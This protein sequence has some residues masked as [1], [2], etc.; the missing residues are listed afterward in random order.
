MKITYI[1]SLYSLKH[2]TAV[3]FWTSDA[4]GERERLHRFQITKSKL[5]HMEAYSNLQN[6]RL[7]SGT[8]PDNKSKCSRKT[9]LW[10]AIKRERNATGLSQ[11]INVRISP[12]SL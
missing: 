3:N 9:L 10:K 11:S 6:E 12:M 4:T 2:R 5:K 8:T 7:I 1:I